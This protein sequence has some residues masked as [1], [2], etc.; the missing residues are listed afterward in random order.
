MA[1]ER[2][3]PTCWYI[4][5]TDHHLTFNLQL[6]QSSIVHYSK[7]SK[8]YLVRDFS[9]SN[10]PKSDVRDLSP[11]WFPTHAHT[12]NG[13]CLKIETLSHDFSYDFSS[14]TIFFLKCSPSLP[15]IHSPT[16]NPPPCLEKSVSTLNNREF[17]TLLR[18]LGSERERERERN[19]ERERRERRE[20]ERA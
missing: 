16:L 10:S 6:F 14:F 12:G 15:R 5:S 9:L 19:W 1:D 3:K 11:S 13:W 8:N 17:I 4:H 7:I 20:I 18:E 2:K